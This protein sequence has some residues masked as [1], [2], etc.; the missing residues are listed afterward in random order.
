MSP[1]SRI[2][3]RS[4]Q[5]T[6]P[7]GVRLILPPIEVAAPSFNPRTR[8]GCDKIKNAEAL[9]T[10]SFNPRTREGC[11]LPALRLREPERAVSIHAPARGATG[12]RRNHPHFCQSFNP[13]TREGCDVLLRHKD[14]IS[15]G[16]NPRTREGCDMFTDYRIFSICCF[17][18]RTREGCDLLLLLL[19]YTLDVSIHAPAR[20]ATIWPSDWRLRRKMFQSTHPRG[21]RPPISGVRSHM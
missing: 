4:F 7:R 15:K 1:S 5:S 16:F 9:R 14:I 17:N 8:E 11:D 18:P 12:K 10:R 3:P 21:V 2:T 20:G 13:R 6:H 19:L